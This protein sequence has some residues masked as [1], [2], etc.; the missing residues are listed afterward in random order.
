MSN[1]RRYYAEGYS[2]FIT[3]VTYN[4]ER[5]LV[6]YV[7]LFWES[8]EFA[9]SI[10]P[11]SINAWVILPEHF[12][13]ILTP[14]ENTLS[15]IIKRFK[16]SFSMR[17]YKEIEVPAGRVWQYRFWDHAIRDERD[18]EAHFHYIHYNHTKHGY[19]KKPYDYKHSS[20][21]KFMDIYD[22]DWAMI[23]DNYHKYNFGE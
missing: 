21:H 15:E 17:Y 6:D 11:F 12:H 8:M 19:V 18:F 1:L 7:N 9:S 20:M 2:Y 3:V 14:E 4:R 16:L 23:E 5:F 13:M 22:S 10:I